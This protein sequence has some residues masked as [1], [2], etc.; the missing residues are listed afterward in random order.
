MCFYVVAFVVIEVVHRRRS[1]R[2]QRQRLHCGR[3]RRSGIGRLRRRQVHVFAGFSRRLHAPLALVVGPLGSL[4]RCMSF[5]P[6]V[7]RALRLVGGGAKQVLLLIGGLVSVRGCRTNGA[8]LRG[9]DFGFS[10]FVHRVCR[11]F[12]DITS[13]QRVH[14]ILSGRLPR[15]CGIYF[16]RTRVRG[17]FFGL[18]SGTFGF[19][20]S[21][22]RIAVHIGAIARTRYRLL[23]RFPT[24]CDSVLVRTKCL[25][26]RI[27][28]AKGNFDRRR[29]RGVFRPFCHSRRSVRQRVSNA[30]VKL[31]LAHS[32]VLRRGNYV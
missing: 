28:S 31:D 1:G 9:A 29:T 25:F 14:F 13:G 4:V 17:M 16:S 30:N 24:R 19:A 3:V 26:V 21:R 7:G 2:R 22:K 23:P 11:S 32:V 5:S 15:A 12:R 10:S 6:R 8:I 18:L 20:P 27:V